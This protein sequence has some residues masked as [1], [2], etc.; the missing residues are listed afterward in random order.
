MNEKKCGDCIHWH[1]IKQ[2]G[3]RVPDLSAPKVGE[4]RVEPPTFLGMQRV[5]QGMAMM[6]AY[7]SIQSDFPAC[8]R[9]EVGRNGQGDELKVALAKPG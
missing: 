6:V 2:Q 7:K 9:H 4:C 5:Q 8:F 1:R 3:E